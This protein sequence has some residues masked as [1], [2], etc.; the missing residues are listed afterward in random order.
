MLADKK[1]LVTGG[2]GQVARPIAELLA[3]D[4]EV[5]C[6]ARFSSSQAREELEALGITTLSWDMTSRDLDVMPDDFTHVV[7]SAVIMTEDHDDAVRLNAEAAGALMWHCRAAEQ[8][9]YVSAMG[10]YRR[11]DPSRPCRETDE[12]G[13]AASFRPSYPAGKLATE[14]AVRALA[15]VLNLPTTI[16]RY[17]VGYGPYGHGGLPVY[18]YQRIK[19]GEPIFVPFGYEN[20]CAPIHTD[21]TAAQAAKLL[22]VA[23]VPA[24]IVNWAGDDNITQRQLATHIADLVGEELILE[25]AEITFDSPASDNTRRQALIGQC[26]VNWIDGIS[27]LIGQLESGRFN[28]VPR[29]AARI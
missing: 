14:G 26:E 6:P 23:T 22:A 27:G 11:R 7:H 4:N 16:A 19:A 18:Y 21:D 12:L 29:P 17:N 24:T 2:T 13:G 5:W 28:P 1:I 15:S 25:K 3:R 20:W 10:V 9:L 8:F